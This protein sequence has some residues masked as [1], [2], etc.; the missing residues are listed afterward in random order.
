MNADDGP[1]YR[2]HYMGWGSKHDSVERE[3]QLRKLDLTTGLLKVTSKPKSKVS[4]S[5][6][7]IPASNKHGKTGKLTKVPKRKAEVAESVSADQI[8]PTKKAQSSVGLALEAIV[9]LSEAAGFVLPPELIKWLH[10]DTE[11]VLKMRTL[12]ALPRK[13][14]VTIILDMFDENRASVKEA[15]NDNPK[16]DTLSGPVQGLR[17]LFDRMIGG[18]L[19]Y[20]FERPQYSRLLK[21]AP[22]IAPCDIYGAEHLLRLMVLL[23]EMI[24]ASQPLETQIAEM[25]VIVAELMAFLM[26]DEG[27]YFGGDYCLTNEEYLDLL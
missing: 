19:L 15:G 12:V 2:V 22:L 20:R 26:K 11:Q 9:P 25:G 16:R 5:A 23:P 13:H 27:E 3:A 10:H 7:T 24:A 6:T 1:W 18:R 4:G 21:A 14:T 8:P 17:D